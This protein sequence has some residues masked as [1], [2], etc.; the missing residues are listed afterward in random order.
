MP[1]FHSSGLEVPILSG[2][3]SH[4]TGARPFFLTCGAGPLRMESDSTPRRREQGQAMEGYQMTLVIVPLSHTP[5][6]YSQQGPTYGWR[7]EA[8]SYLFG[9]QGNP[10]A[11]ARVAFFSL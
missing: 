9:F 6:T 11:E 3:P 2:A 10:L 4:T 5:A 1:G 8:T 7:P